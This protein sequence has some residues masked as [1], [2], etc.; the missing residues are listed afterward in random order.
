MARQQLTEYCFFSQTSRRAA[1]QYSKKKKGLGEG[2]KEPQNKKCYRIKGSV[3][4]PENTPKL[5]L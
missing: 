1:H 5:S 2:G 4:H 3:T